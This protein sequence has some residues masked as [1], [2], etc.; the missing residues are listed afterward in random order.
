MVQLTDV[1][2]RE[3]Y[4]YTLWE[5]E[6]AA[7]TPLHIFSTTKEF[8]KKITDQL[9]KAITDL[10]IPKVYYMRMEKPH[11][12][13]T[14]PP[15]VDR[16]RRAAIN[17]Y[18]DCNKEVTEFFE[19]EESSKT[20]I[21]KGSFIATPNDVWLLNVSKPH[22]VRMKSAKLRSAISLSF[23]KLKAEKILKLI[24]YK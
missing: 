21:S 22:A 4:K 5:K 6:I 19:A 11:A 15:H 14:V 12:D 10:E 20:L 3:K 9:P 18:I 16:G 17:I 7:P 2:D 24:G 13:S 1:P 23:R 8:A